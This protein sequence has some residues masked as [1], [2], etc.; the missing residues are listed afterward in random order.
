LSQEGNNDNNRKDLDETSQDISN[1]S[2]AT[3]DEV[4]RVFNGNKARLTTRKEQFAR[5]ASTA[6][7]D[8]ERLTYK[9]LS[10]DAQEKRY[11]LNWIESLIIQN[12]ALKN[13]IDIV[14]DIVVQL[15]EVKGHPQMMKDIDDAFKNFDRSNF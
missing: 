14:K 15:G 8:F 10:K 3:L 13:Q 4:R 11:L 12:F 7:S 2:P 5:L 6:S 1:L 9:D